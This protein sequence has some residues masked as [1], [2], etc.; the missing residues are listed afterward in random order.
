[1][2]TG[3]PRPPDGNDS[4]PT[5]RTLEEL[6][7]APTAPDPEALLREAGRERREFGRDLARR[8]TIPL[9]E[10]ADDLLREGGA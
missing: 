2:V 7:A 4:T 8:L 1:M 10:L 5:I 9:D 6:M 3:V